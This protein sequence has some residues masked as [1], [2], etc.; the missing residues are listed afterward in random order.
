M[1]DVFQGPGWWM[2]SD[3]KWYP[4]ERHPDINYRNQH[5]VAKPPSD[6]P[7]VGIHNNDDTET[8]STSTFS[9][10]VI[11]RSAQ[12]DETAEISGQELSDHLE[13]V[14]RQRQEAAEQLAA[15]ER[16]AQ[17]VAEQVEAQQRAA[18]STSARVSDISTGPD[19]SGVETK[20]A[21]VQRGTSLAPERSIP[22]DLGR[23]K[24]SR[25][26]SVASP[27][28]VNPPERPVFDRTVPPSV[29]NAPARKPSVPGRTELELDVPTGVRLTPAPVT[30]EPALR[31]STALVHVPSVPLQVAS[32]KDRVLASLLFISGIAMIIGTF[33][34]WTID[35]IAET[36]WVR[37]D[38][39]ATILAGVVGSA[40]AGPIFVGFRHVLPKATAIV[41]GLVGVVVVGLAAINASGLGIGIYVELVAAIVMVGAAAADQGDALD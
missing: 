33:L 36:G 8:T 26:F 40:M 37:G 4:P 1:S 34:E 5:A 31:P 21:A 9:E 3:G 13:Q 35:P 41:A 30:A 39:I 18:E 15:Q 14:E 12:L 25:A 11:S 2:A 38:G 7:A 20:P 23:P 24:P 19:G 29:V 17:L 32:T 10:M 27:D 28:F 6:F 16:E 22:Q